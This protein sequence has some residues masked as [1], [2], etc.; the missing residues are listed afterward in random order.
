[1]KNSFVFVYLNPI[2]RNTLLFYMRDEMKR[3]KENNSIEMTCPFKNELEFTQTEK[4]NTP[5]KSLTSAD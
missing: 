1:M 4:R 3:E 2:D 5:S